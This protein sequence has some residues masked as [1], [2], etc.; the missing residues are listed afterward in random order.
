[1]FCCK[2]ADYISLQ[3]RAIWT[4]SVRFQC[5]IRNTVLISGTVSDKWNTSHFRRK[6]KEKVRVFIFC[7]LRCIFV[8]NHV[9]NE[10]PIQKM[11]ESILIYKLVPQDSEQPP[12]FLILPEQI[13]KYKCTQTKTGCQI[14]Y[15]IRK[16]LEKGPNDK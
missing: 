15:F 2:I 6:R 14:V 10:L 12:F 7:T 16:F 3:I 8:C 4:A 1:M 11:C 9:S 13:I 5:N